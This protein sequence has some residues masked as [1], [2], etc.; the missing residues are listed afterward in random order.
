MT[1]GIPRAR[2]ELFAAHLLSTTGFA[3]QSVSH[4]FR[5]ALSAAEAALLLLDRA[6]GPD[7][8][9]V[10]AAFIRHVVRERGMDPDAGRQLRSL[11]NRAVQANADGAVPQPEAP[12]AIDDATVVVD[13]VAAWIE[14]S[15]RA[16]AQ[17]APSGGGRPPSKQ[18][19]KRR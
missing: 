5:A 7:P 3:A 12:A 13:I 10:V 16:A 18:G 8:T 1:T 4:A 11:L 2:E 15:N 19:R 9:V 14:G 17:R 6:P